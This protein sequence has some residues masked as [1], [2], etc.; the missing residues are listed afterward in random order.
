V[1][2]ERGRF[3]DGWY[4]RLR[5]AYVDTMADQGG[6]QPPRAHGLLVECTD[7]EHLEFDL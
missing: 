4:R 6:P 5:D 1:R 7:L 3:L 2:Q